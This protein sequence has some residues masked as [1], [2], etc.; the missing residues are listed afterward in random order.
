MQN[1]IWKDILY[2][3]DK[4][5]VSNLGNVK[6]LNF[7]RS[8]KSRNLKTCLR[9]GHYLSVDLS[10]NNKRV[11]YFVHKLVSNAFLGI[12]KLQ[13][14]H[15]N[16]IK[17]DNKLENLELVT[18]SENMQHATKMGLCDERNR[19]TGERMRKLLSID[20]PNCKLDEEKAL[21]IRELH[22]T[23]NYTIKY[24]AKFYGVSDT[25]VSYVIKNKTW[26]KLSIDN[27]KK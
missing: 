16:G 21:K 20:S 5:Q 7:N 12:S 15:K 23:G 10:K 14:N 22:K 1:E 18:R 25:T 24:L 26:I 19:K 11:T 3:E 8:G 9:D 13:V 17:T 2:Y 4:Y 27:T 6:S